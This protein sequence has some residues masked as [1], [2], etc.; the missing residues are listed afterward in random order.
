MSWVHWNTIEGQGSL[1]QWKENIFLDRKLLP[2][3]L[4]LPLST[5]NGS[6][7]E[8]QNWPVIFILLISSYVKYSI[9]FPFYRCGNWYTKKLSHMEW[10]YKFWWIWDSFVLS[11]LIIRDINF[12]INCVVNRHHVSEE[13]KSLNESDLRRIITLP[14]SLKVDHFHDHILFC[15]IPWNSIIDPRKHHH[16][17]I[18]THVLPY[19]TF[20][21]WEY[22]WESLNE[23]PKD[24]SEMVADFTV[25]R[26][27]IK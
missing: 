14:I 25:F 24:N 20:N 13:Q 21:R 18:F 10:E 11:V 6:F 4:W 16:S 7:T 23:Q 22:S 8:P 12:S 19:L 2:F 27:F 26:I 9:T 17:M 5:I 3:L 1:P 15:I